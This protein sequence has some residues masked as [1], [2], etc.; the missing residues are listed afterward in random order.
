MP[1]TA[2][3]QV[4]GMALLASLS[5]IVFQ[6]NTLSFT[7]HSVLWIFLGLV[8]AWYSAIKHHSPDFTVKFG[9][10]DAAGVVVGCLAYVFVILPL[11]LK[12]KGE[13]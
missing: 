10:K 5:G 1:G 12:A 4:W 7:Y 2:A 11:F 3:V 13:M 9:W 8:G 6:I